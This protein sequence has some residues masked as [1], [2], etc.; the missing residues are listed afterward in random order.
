MD[1]NLSAQGSSNPKLVITLECGVRNSSRES[2]LSECVIN[3]LAT[4][5]IKIWKASENQSFSNFG[6]NWIFEFSQNV[7]KPG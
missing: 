5:Q 7:R 1:E 2:V 6:D 3:D 4:T